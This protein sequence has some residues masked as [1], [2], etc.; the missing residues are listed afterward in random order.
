MDL[1]SSHKAWLENIATVQPPQAKKFDLII[2]PG[3]ARVLWLG[4]TRVKISLAWLDTSQAKQASA[5]LV[6]TA[7]AKVLPIMNI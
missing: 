6:D 3:Q 5:G 4:L 1:L 7:I 2:K